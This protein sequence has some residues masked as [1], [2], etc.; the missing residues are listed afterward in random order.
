M[1]D[2]P[3]LTARGGGSQVMKQYSQILGRSQLGQS[4]G[5]VRVQ[6]QHECAAG[7]ILD[8]YRLPALI[9]GRQETCNASNLAR[10]ARVLE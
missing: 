8:R 2:L 10:K 5:E 9:L 4:G 7:L 6:Q 1:G 3:A